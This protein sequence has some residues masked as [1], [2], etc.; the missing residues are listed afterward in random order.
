ME[1]KEAV[2]GSTQI[3]IPEQDENS[4]FPP[5]TAQIFYNRRMAINRDA[6][7]LLL[8][9]A[10]P[11]DYV[12]AMG[13]TGIRGL[14]VA[15][16]CDI[17]TT[18]ND[19]NPRAV[20]MI[21]TNVQALGLGNVHVSCEDANVLLSGKRFD[22]VDIDP[23]GTPAPFIDSAVRATRRFL[24]VT[25]TDT[26]PLCGAHKKAG[27]RRY[28]SNPLNTEYHAEVGLRTLLGFVARE[29]VKYDRGIVP[30]F[31]FSHEHFI[32]LHLRLTRGARA[33]D[34]TIGEIGYI[35]QC[36]DCAFRKEVRGLV[37]EGHRCEH[38]GA[39]LIPVG[40]LWTGGLQS[41][42]ILDAMLSCLPSMHLTASV[43]LEKI[44]VLCREE[45]PVPWCYDYH[46]L[47]KQEHCSPVPLG[48][49]LSSLHARGYPAT[50]CHYLGTGIKTTA[51]LPLILSIIRGD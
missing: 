33:A 43:E 17:E 37:L 26:A 15:N 8:S 36:P 4:A 42:E 6:T 39:T 3:L 11:S 51:P 31:C 28:F 41:C 13:A 5:G 1:L 2:E 9:V 50:R 22:A 46:Q 16:E 29:T 19:R 21:Q 27:I 12:D 32:R 35:M 30:L 18:I 23:F 45:L 47:A 20:S 25:A 14:R 44:I 40:P 38:C 48:H 7:V 34:R 10:R 24:F 49:L